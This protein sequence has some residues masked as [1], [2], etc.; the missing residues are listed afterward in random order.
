V[1]RSD[2]SSSVPWFWFDPIAPDRNII[3]SLPF[4]AIASQE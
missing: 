4:H 3:S 2:L 1:V